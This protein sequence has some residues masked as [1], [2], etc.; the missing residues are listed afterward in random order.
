MST[1]ALCLHQTCP[2]KMINLENSSTLQPFNT[3]AKHVCSVM[4]L[5]TETYSNTR[6][7]IIIPYCQCVGVTVIVSPVLI[8]VHTLIALSWHQQTRVDDH[9]QSRWLSKGQPIHTDQGSSTGQTC[10]VQSSAVRPLVPHWQAPQLSRQRLI[11]G[12][13]GWQQHQLLHPVQG[14][15][16]GLLVV[17][18]FSKSKQKTWYDIPLST[19]ACLFERPHKMEQI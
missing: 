8:W 13:L 1:L 17:N 16:W 18:P 4:L 5:A 19:S 9:N 12:H 14:L 7:L 15:N 6:S 10:H 11:T 3:K 2:I